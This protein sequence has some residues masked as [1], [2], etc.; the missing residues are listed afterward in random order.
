M[1]V[2]PEERGKVETVSNDFASKLRRQRTARGRG[3][4]RLIKSRFEGIRRI[5][6]P[7]FQPA[8]PIHQ[9]RGEMPLW[10][11]WFPLSRSGRAS[12]G[13]WLSRGAYSVMLEFIYQGVYRDELDNLQGFDSALYLKYDKYLRHLKGRVL[14]DPPSD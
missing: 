5:D 10:L 4:Q 6:A 14:S 13:D 7:Y 3:L 11:L 8:S 2:D 12:P 9:E 1:E